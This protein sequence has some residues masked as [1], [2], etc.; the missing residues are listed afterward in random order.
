MS[1]SEVFAVV[2]SSVAILLSVITYWNNT[3]KPFNLALFDVGRVELT[4]NPYKA[5]NREPALLV[6]LIFLNKGAKSG[7]VQDAALKLKFPNGEDILFRSIV[8][9]TDRTLQ[10]SKDLAPPKLESFIG[11]NIPGRSS[12][13]KHIMFV[14]D[15]PI[16]YEL[17]P[18]GRFIVEIFAISGGDQEWKS[19]G[20][21]AFSVDKNDLEVLEKIVFTQQPDGRYFLKWYTQSKVTEARETSIKSIK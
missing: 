17:L 9:S 2:L 18:Q 21:F 19:Y 11:F 14:P 1:V 5:P 16:Q 3:L 8:I 20:S 15:K 6:E 7:V 13:H 12:V 10:F 4:V